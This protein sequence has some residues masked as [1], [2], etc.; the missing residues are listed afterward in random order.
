M[1]KALNKHETY[2]QETGKAIKGPGQILYLLGYLKN[3][4]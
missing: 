1:L 2:G 3:N 4:D